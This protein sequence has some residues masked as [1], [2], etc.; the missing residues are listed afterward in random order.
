MRPKLT[1]A[2]ATGMVETIESLHRQIAEVYAAADREYAG[3]GNSNV[4]RDA[5]KARAEEREAAFSAAGY[6]ESFDVEEPG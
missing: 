6:L 5:V 1:T 4:L 3:T 2:I